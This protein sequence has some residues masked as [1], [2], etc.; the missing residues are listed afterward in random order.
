MV[1]G[2]EV[3]SGAEVPL[4]VAVGFSG[5]AMDAAEV[6]AADVPGTEAAVVPAEV[7]G[8]ESGFSAAGELS[9]RAADVPAEV[10]GFAEMP[11]AVPTVEDSAGAGAVPFC[12]AH[13]VSIA[14]AQI[15]AVNDVL[16]I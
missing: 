7:S 3:F 9:P 10:P 13:P 6:S 15:I 11:G 14:A 4:E 12:E 8:E 5:S 16:F 1:I 2:A